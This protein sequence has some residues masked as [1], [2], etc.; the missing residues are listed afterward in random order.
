MTDSDFTF[1]IIDAAKQR[2]LAGTPEPNDPMI[3]LLAE[4]I[5]ANERH[6]D[7]S[8]ER[9]ERHIKAL[10]GI[11]GNGGSKKK[12]AGLTATVAAAAAGIVLGIQQAFGAK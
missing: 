2:Y 3:L 5:A 7:R 6:E 11:N 10:K 9:F 8:D 1:R 12:Q 4:V